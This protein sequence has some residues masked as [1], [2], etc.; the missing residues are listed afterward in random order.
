MLFIYATPTAMR[1]SME[2]LR[3]IRNISDEYK[4]SFRKGLNDVPH[5]FANVQKEDEKMTF[6]IDFLLLKKLTTLAS[7]RKL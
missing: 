2:N 5:R 6:N 7:F 4:D 3:S 1:E